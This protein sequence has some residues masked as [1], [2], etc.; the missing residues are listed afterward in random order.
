MKRLPLMA[1]V[2]LAGCIITSCGEQAKDTDRIKTVKIDTVRTESAQTTL[3]YPG[4]IK[5][6]EDVS[7]AFR[8]SGTIRKIHVKDGQP[9]KAGQ[10]LA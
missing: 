7:L 3:Q 6:A 2:L 5:A 4:K 8:V 10:L 1:A 9:V